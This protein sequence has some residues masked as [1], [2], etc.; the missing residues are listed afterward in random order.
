[1]CVCLVNFMFIFF[2]SCHFAEMLK[3]QLIKIYFQTV[4]QLS[5]NLN[6]YHDFFYYGVMELNLV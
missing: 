4:Q 3:L 2:N 5:K 6:F 1:M